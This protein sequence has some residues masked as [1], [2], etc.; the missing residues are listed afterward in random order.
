V[1]SVFRAS[2]LSKRLTIGENL[3]SQ[4]V[5]SDFAEADEQLLSFS[6]WSELIYEADHRDNPAAGT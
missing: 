2:P 3:A 1:T 4:F 5:G 6:T